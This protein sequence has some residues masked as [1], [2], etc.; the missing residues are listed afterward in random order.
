MISGKVAFID[1]NK[2]GYAPSLKVN[3]VKYGGDAKGA[4]PDIQVGDTV[5]FEAFEA[6]GQ[7][8]K[9]WPKYKLQTL[10]KLPAADATVANG[11]GS[12]ST[13]KVS[14]NVRASYSAGTGGTRESYWAD[15]AKDDSARDPRI[16]YQGALDRAISFATLAVTALALPLPKT[17]SK[18]LEVLQAFVD[19]TA[20]RFMAQTYAAR[21][22][23]D[24]PTK[25][26]PEAVAAT[27][28]AATD[29]PDEDWT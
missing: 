8:G 18:R 24:P 19:E 20:L 26:A 7:N 25:D 4:F 6:P 13:A 21:V 22:P 16:S 14:G 17:E 28:A 23:T 29:A 15:K 10:R 3:G 12:T 11:G 2:F 1:P 5:E 27:T 9:S